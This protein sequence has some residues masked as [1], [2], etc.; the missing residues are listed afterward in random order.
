MGPLYKRSVVTVTRARILY[1]WYSPY[2]FLQKALLYGPPLDL[3]AAQIHILHVA[4]GDLHIYIFGL[5][6]VAGARIGRTLSCPVPNMPGGFPL[7]LVS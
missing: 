1:R 3:S 5:F 6:Q 7:S 2:R 4:M